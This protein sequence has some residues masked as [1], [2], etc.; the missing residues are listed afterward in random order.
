MDAT[1]TTS[2]SSPHSPASP[3]GKPSSST[4]AAVITAPTL[5]RAERALNSGLE[6]LKHSPSKNVDD[7]LALM[8]GMMARATD[9]TSPST[10]SST[11]AIL[12]NPLI[13]RALSSPTVIEAGTRFPG[14][15]AAFEAAIVNSPAVATTLD[16]FEKTHTHYAAV[17]ALHTRAATRV[18][19][20][21]LSIQPD[22][23]LALKNSSGEL[24]SK[25]PG[26]SKIQ[27]EDLMCL[28]VETATGYQYPF[29]LTRDFADENHQIALGAHSRVKSLAPDIANGMT[30][31]GGMLLSYSLLNNVQDCHKANLRKSIL[32]LNKA[33]S[34]NGKSSLETGLVAEVE[35]KPNGYVTAI[36]KIL[37]HIDTLEKYSGELRGQIFGQAAPEIR[38]QSLH[39]FHNLTNQAA[40]LNGSSLATFYNTL[41]KVLAANTA[42]VRQAFSMVENQN[43]EGLIRA[44]YL[45]TQIFTDFAKPSFEMK[46]AG[47]PFVDGQRTPHSALHQ[48]A[49]TELTDL[50]FSLPEI[51]Q[52]KYAPA[53]AS[54]TPVHIW[55]EAATGFI[56]ESENQNHP[57]FSLITRL[58]ARISA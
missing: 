38:E 52:K 3:Q 40:L 24:S 8:L 9:S 54:A 53:T 42:L 11:D 32:E 50:G 41:P 16:S 34:S 47:V 56:S 33:N 25:T 57:L 29:R 30:P 31:T 37:A 6:L 7:S 21:E 1:P 10:T 19:L 2:H 49:W 35:G 13:K 14:F 51:D 12:E 46:Q 39:A 48:A 28:Y 43:F 17:A 36:Q 15:K 5:S 4:A 26:V 58:N 20:L 44:N 23:Q 22:L 45:A 27:I 55:K 18:N